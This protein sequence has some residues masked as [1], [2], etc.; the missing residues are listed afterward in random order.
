[1]IIESEISLLR[2]EAVG[3][4]LLG[5]VFNRTNTD[6]ACTHNRRCDNNRD[7]HSRPMV[8]PRTPDA[9]SPENLWNSP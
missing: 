5:A 4:D 2:R 6:R 7:F 1:M 8:G 3:G 9:R